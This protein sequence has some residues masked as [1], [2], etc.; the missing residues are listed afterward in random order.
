MEHIELGM[1]RFINTMYSLK[2]KERKYLYHC[3]ETLLT[4]M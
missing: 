3:M 2:N 4:D 1:A